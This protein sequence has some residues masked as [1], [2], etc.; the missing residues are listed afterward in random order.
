M[1]MNFRP[2]VED[3]LLRCAELSVNAWPV[4]L[5]ITDKENAYLFMQSY[6]EFSLLLSDYTEVCCDNRKVVGFL[7]GLL[8]KKKL[9]KEE[10]KKKGKLLWHFITGKY[11][12]IKKSFR[13]LCAFI[14]SE[15]KV[16]IL[17]SRF[18]GEV[19]L[20]IVDKEY[21]GRGIGRKLLTNFL[22]YARNK[23]LKTFIYILILKVAGKF[24]K[25]MGSRNYETFMI[26]GCR[27]W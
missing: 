1:D 3:D 19:I 17:C 11:G 13:F 7:F 23:S 14:L 27:L 12:R 24:K 9:S 5:M 15:I 18:D 10:K 2:Y 6:T 25:I 22:N 16:K 21:Q 20:F 8:G 4:V 26:M